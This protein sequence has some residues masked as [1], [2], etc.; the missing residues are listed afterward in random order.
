MPSYRVV[1]WYDP[2]RQGAY[3]EIRTCQQISRGIPFHDKIQLLNVCVNQHQDEI[4]GFREKKI[5]G[6]YFSFFMLVILTK[7]NPQMLYQKISSQP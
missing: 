3:G 1:S 6:L 5:Y 4:P 2:R 7:K